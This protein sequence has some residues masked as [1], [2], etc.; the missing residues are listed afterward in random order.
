M[1]NRINGCKSLS[2]HGQR[3]VYP[4]WTALVS[5]GTVKPEDGQSKTS[6]L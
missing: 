3:E 6:V 1:L 4:T 5:L 2:A